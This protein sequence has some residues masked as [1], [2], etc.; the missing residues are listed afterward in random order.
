MFGFQCQ[1][2]VVD[3]RCL[4]IIFGSMLIRI[5]GLFLEFADLVFHR[6]DLSVSRQQLQSHDINLI[7]ELVVFTHSFVQ[8]EFLVLQTMGK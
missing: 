1:N 3:V 5:D 2:L 8:Q 7:V 6:G 4:H